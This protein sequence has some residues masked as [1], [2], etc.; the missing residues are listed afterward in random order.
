[1]VRSPKM[2]LNTRALLRGVALEAAGYQL[3]IEKN[4]K[5][6]L[7][8]NQISFP[9][10]LQEFIEEVQSLANGYFPLKDSEVWKEQVKSVYR[11]LKHADAEPSELLD[12]YQMVWGSI[13]VLRVWIGLRLGC[14]LKVMLNRASFDSIKR[15]IYN[16]VTP[17]ENILP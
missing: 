7:S 15:K 11:G 4:D 1:M 2:D 3:A 6:K 12:I 9:T 10:A 16:L 13:F 8:N 14:D 17:E 5:T